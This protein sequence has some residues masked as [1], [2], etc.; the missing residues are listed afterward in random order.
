MQSSPQFVF[1]FD[2]VMNAVSVPVSRN[3]VYDGRN[4]MIREDGPSGTTYHLYSGDRLVFQYQPAQNRYVE[5]FY[6][7]RI[8]VG[9]RGVNDADKGDSDG[10]GV[11]DAAQFL[12]CVKCS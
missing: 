1:G 12:E 4:R 7:G 9:S 3:F 11:P 6:L 5:Y 8:L 10:D 2:S